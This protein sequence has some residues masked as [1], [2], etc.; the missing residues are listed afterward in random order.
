MYLS[1]VYTVTVNLAGLPALSVPLGRGSDGLPFGGQLI[2]PDFGESLLFQAGAVLE[3]AFP[4][5]LPPEV[6]A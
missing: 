5:E 3:Q 2:G 1:D 6:E 4:A